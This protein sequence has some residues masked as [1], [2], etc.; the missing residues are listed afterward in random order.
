MRLYAPRKYGKTS[1]L[2]RALRDGEAQEGLIPVLVD[3]Y[4]VVSVA[5][6]TIRFE[7][8][9]ARHLK[10]PIRA[11]VE[12]LLQRTGLG[13]SLGAFGISA[14]IQIDPKTE[15]LAA[16]HTLLDLPSKLEEGGGFRAFVAL[17]E[18][19][20]VTKIPDLDGLIRSHIQ[21]QGE[22]ASYV[23]AGS[24]PGL[25][26]QLFESRDRPLGSAVPLRLG[27]L[28]DPDIAEYVARRF[29]QTERSVG[30]AL[31]PL[32]SAAQ[33]HPQRAIMLAHHLWERVEPR[34]AA[35]LEHWELAHAR[36]LSELEPEFDAMWRGHQSTVAQKTLRSIVA[37]EGSAYRSAILGRLEL[38]KSVAGAALQRLLDSADIE[39]AGGGKY[40]V[41]DLFYAEWIGRIDTGRES[42]REDGR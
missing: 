5:D 16:L 28:D 37:G 12:E 31:N 42:E 41:V 35:T 23:F 27:R 32:L 33:G 38:E 9:C 26:K 6:V 8:A 1:L 3:L 10:G 18:F 36:T 25:M 39:E 21:H 14:R 17:D 4:R 20:D 40:R 7:R 34:G 2:K 11:R 13:L 30:D 19:Q 22:V 29:S 24:E 15:P